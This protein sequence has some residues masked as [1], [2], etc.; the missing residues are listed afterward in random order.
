MR[1]RPVRVAIAAVAALTAAAAQPRFDSGVAG[2]LENAALD[3]RSL[4]Y[5]TELTRTVGAR[6]S[7]TAAYERA[8]EWTA[9]Q[10]RAAGVDRVALEPFVMPRGWA[11]EGPVVAN[12][13]APVER[14]LVVEPLG[15]TPPLPNDAIEGEVVVGGQEL[16]S[17][18]NRVR[19]RIVLVDG[20]IRRDFDRRVRDLGAR[21][22]LFADTSPDNLI[23]ARVRNFGG[24]LA[25]MPAAAI[26]T[27]SADALRDLLRRG[28]VRLQI[29][30]RAR[31]T[32]GPVA[33]ANVVGE[34]I[35][36]ERPDEF[37][38]VGAHLDSWDSATGA[39]DNATGVAMV[40]EAARAIAALGRP[41]IRSIRFALWGGEE[42]G[43][44]GSTAYVRA[45]ARELDR[46]VAVLNADGGTGRIIGW[47]TPGRDDVMAAVK[48]LS[49]AVLTRLRADAVDRKMQ[50][51]FDSDGGP[52]IA[53]GI[54]VLDLN[55]DD[56]AY[57]DIHHK[58]TDTIDRVDAG[59]LAVGA[60]AVAVTAYVIADL[61]ER[62]AP[63]GP[64]VE[65]R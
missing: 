26:A 41:P 27:D 59:N 21:A 65:R 48:A 58:S 1:F 16:A 11:R 44:L 3:G 43:L 52:F 22:L 5:V 31:A 2:R 38:V 20:A 17:A 64:K 14:P 46:L 42:Q 60:A 10:L 19:G 7:A 28:P 23:A 15:W 63:R 12:I 61:P 34:V 30:Y 18:P 4:A 56:R 37:V 47:T 55:V 8:A 29:S 13:V 62:I 36:R 6:L 49:E 33:V 50:Y 9:G 24:D 32:E 39:Q 51:A 35:G 25:P 53:E 54:P 57:D 45:H 40:L